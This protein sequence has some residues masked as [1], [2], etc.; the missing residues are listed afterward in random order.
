MDSSRVQGYGL[1]SLTISVIRFHRCH[2]DYSI[3][4][5]RMKPGIVVLAVPFDDILFTGRFSCAIGD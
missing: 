1:K 2:S 4:V 5:R 3:F